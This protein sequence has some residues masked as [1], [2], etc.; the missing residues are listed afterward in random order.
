M[1][2]VGCVMRACGTGMFSHRSQIFTET[3]RAA[4]IKKHGYHRCA[5]M[6]LFTDCLLLLRC[7]PLGFDAPTAQRIGFFRMRKVRSGAK[8]LWKSARSVGDN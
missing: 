1:W 7:L 5:R 3:V 8:N 2:D 4:F 6:G